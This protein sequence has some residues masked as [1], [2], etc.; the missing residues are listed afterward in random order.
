MKLAIKYIDNEITDPE[1]QML[2]YLSS[3]VLIYV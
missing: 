1:R 2:H 3:V